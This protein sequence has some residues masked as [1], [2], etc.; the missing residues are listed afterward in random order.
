MRAGDLRHEVQI[1][2][3]IVTQGP[4]GAE[5]ITW[6]S[7]GTLRARIDPLRG[8]EKF[9]A[10][11]PLAELDTRI[12]IRWSPNNDQITEKWRVVH[13]RVI[14]DIK[15]VIHVRLAQR[16]IDLMCKSGVNNG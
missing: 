10:E 15:N 3:P 11:Q 7:F 12:R 2:Y 8:D 9:F 6:G 14:Y 13:N 4:S 5:A 16:T 1:Q